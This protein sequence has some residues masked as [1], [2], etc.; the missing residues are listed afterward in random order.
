MASVVLDEDSVTVLLNNGQRLTGDV[1]GI[2]PL[3]DVALLK[4]DA[5]DNGFSHFDLAE[6]GNAYEAMRV[7]AFSNLYNIATG[8]EPVSVQHGVLTAIAP[9]EARRAPSPPATATMSISWT[10]PS[11]TLAPQ[12]VY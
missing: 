2:D 1:V 6:Q 8:D 5:E 9:L 4:L 3:T 10:P 12:V 11:I 7:L